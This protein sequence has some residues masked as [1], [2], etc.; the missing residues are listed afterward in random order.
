MASEV[1]QAMKP[2]STTA[3]PALLSDLT[4]ARPPACLQAESL[5]GE[6][7]GSSSWSPPSG[8]ERRQALPPPPPLPPPPL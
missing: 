5:G 8:G 7:S 6:A 1:G 2:T 4:H 3:G